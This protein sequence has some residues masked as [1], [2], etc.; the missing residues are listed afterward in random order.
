MSLAIDTT[1]D[2]ILTAIR[3]FILSVLPT[4]V[5][6]VA[7]LDNNVPMPAGDFVVVT[8]RASDRL[9]LN[10]I[11]TYN[12]PSGSGEPPTLSSVTPWKYRVELDIYSAHSAQY[13]LMLVG[14]LRSTY[15]VDNFP[16]PVVPLDC[17]DPKQLP[18]ITAGQNWLERWRVEFAAQVNVT[19]TADTT[20]ATSLTVDLA[21][22]D[23][24]FAP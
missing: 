17:D 21:P 8:A 13:A 7:G 12:E 15:G 14:I 23:Q 19:V 6:V 11:D 1:G 5:E 20:S 18:F 3:S 16:A 24:T 22:I 2:D 4:G 10:N 9:A